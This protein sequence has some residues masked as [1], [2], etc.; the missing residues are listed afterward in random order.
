MRGEE[1]RKFQRGQDLFNGHPTIRFGAVGVN[2]HA[3]LPNSFL[4]A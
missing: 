3:L 1:S 4:R 2:H